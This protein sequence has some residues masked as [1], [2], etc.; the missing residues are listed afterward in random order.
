[1]CADVQFRFDLQAS[2]VHTCG[3]SR[4]FGILQP[5][6]SREREIWRGLSVNKRHRSADRLFEGE[7]KEFS[8]WSIESGDLH[9]EVQRFLNHI[10]NLPLTEEKAEAPHSRIHKTTVGAP[11]AR[12]GWHAATCRLHQTL[13]LY[14][15][16]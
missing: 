2:C 3:D 8:A 4:S 9:A 12:K 1:M 14:D 16:L 6:A 7:L 5:P 10:K 15:R 13:D 11:G